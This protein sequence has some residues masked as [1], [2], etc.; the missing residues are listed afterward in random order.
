MAAFDDDRRALNAS[1]V[2]ISSN[3]AKIRCKAKFLFKK[4]CQSLANVV[5]ADISTKKNHVESRM[6]CSEEPQ[7]A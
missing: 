3:Q 2:I 5:H 1:R 7:A 4:A 6:G